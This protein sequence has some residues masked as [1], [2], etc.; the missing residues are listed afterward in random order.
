MCRLIFCGVRPLIVSLLVNCFYNRGFGA[1]NRFF[2]RATLTAALGAALSGGLAGAEDAKPNFIIILA[3]DMGYGDLSVYGNTGYETPHLDAMAAEG[4][5]F[6][7]FHSNGNVC[8]PTRAAFLTGRYQQRAGLASVVFAPFDRNRHTGLQMEDVTF[9]EVFKDAGYATAL[10][11]KWHLGYE[12]QYNPV[13]SGF[14]R[15]R[16]YV[17]GNVDYQS[18]YEGQEVHDWWDGAKI[19]AETGYTTHL[20]T[21]H[22]VSFLE[23]IGDKPFCLYIAHESPHFPLQGPGD[24]PVRGPDKVEEEMSPEEEQRA[25]REMVQEMDKSVG[26]VLRA[27]RRLDL[28]DNTFV[29][30]FSDNGA[31]DN[32][33]NL[34][35]RGK[36]NTVWEGGHRIP[37]IA[38]QPGK[39]AAGTVT[40]Q[41]AIG[42]DLMPTMLELAGVAAPADRKLDGVSLVP[43]IFE[44]KSLE[45]RQLFWNG[46]AMRDGPWKLVV[47]EKGFEGPGLFNL[48]DDLGET[49]NLAEK[50][51]R[52]LK[53]MLK[54]TQEWEADVADGA[55]VQPDGPS[56]PWPELLREQGQSPYQVP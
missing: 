41:L 51:P 48:A 33:S 42:M 53:R 28:V 36:K 27:V 24:P 4:L 16:G 11:G 25:R 30:F 52:R 9:A 6:T 55:T 39:I 29:F 19:F 37:A 50:Q 23:Q 22:S 31:T 49:V 35:L 54:A 7:D 17:S 26:A 14:D 46:E 38:W 1:M 34:P 43:V 12:R 56:K 15:F 5:R 2:L 32:G 40:D 8:S 3:D 20:I 21:K 18:H 45:R 47:E 10:F 13:F 44:G